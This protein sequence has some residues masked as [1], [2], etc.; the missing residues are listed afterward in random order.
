M[1][2]SEELGELMCRNRMESVKTER[3]SVQAEVRWVNICCEKVSDRLHTY[4]CTSRE[5]QPNKIIQCGSTETP[6]VKVLGIT[7]SKRSLRERRNHQKMSIFFKVCW[8]DNE[9]CPGGETCLWIAPRLLLFIKVNKLPNRPF[10]RAFS[11]T[12]NSKV[13]KDLIISATVSVSSAAFSPML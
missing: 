12:N 13:T 9:G 5:Q 2:S 10:L 11:S 4:S 8:L 6:T 3:A 7:R 1:H